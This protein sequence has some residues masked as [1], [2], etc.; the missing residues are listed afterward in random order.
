MGKA[1]PPGKAKELP[2]VVEG[3]SED[4]DEEV[5]HELVEKKVKWALLVTMPL[6]FLIAIA[7]SSWGRGTWLGARRDQEHHWVLA[8]TRDITGCLQGLGCCQMPARTRDLSGACGAWRCHRMFMGT[9][10]VTRCSW[11]KGALPDGQ[12]DQGHCLVLAGTLLAAHRDQGHHWVFTG[13]GDIG[14]RS[15]G[16]TLPVAFRDWGHCQ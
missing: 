4:D 7:R 8:G 10:D 6:G 16:L 1:E 14:V 3:S 13:T 11:E 2:K 9:R 5:D 15:L 12:R